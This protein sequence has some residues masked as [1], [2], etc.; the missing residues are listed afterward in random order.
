MKPEASQNSCLICPFS[1]ETVDRIRAGALELREER[2][3]GFRS[4]AKAGESGRATSPGL[5]SRRPSREPGEAAGDPGIS[6]GESLP[7][8]REL[9][10]AAAVNDPL[11]ST[12][13]VRR[14]LYERL[15]RRQMQRCVAS[16]YGWGRWSQDPWGSYG[17]FCKWIIR[18]PDN[19]MA[20][21]AVNETSAGR[22]YLVRGILEGLGRLDYP[23]M[24]AETL[25][26]C[27]VCGGAVSLHIKK[28]TGW[29]DFCSHYPAEPLPKRLV[30]ER[31]G[32][33]YPFDLLFPEMASPRPVSADDSARGAGRVNDDLFPELEETVASFIIGPDSYGP[34]TGY[35][36][37]VHNAYL[38]PF[39]LVEAK[40]RAEAHSGLEGFLVYDATTHSSIA[41]LSRRLSAEE[42]RL[43]D[44]S[45][46]RRMIE[47]LMRQSPEETASK[48]GPVLRVQVEG[49]GGVTLEQSCRE[50]Q[51][52]LLKSFDVRSKEDLP[53]RLQ[54]KPLPRLLARTQEFLLE[55]A[56]KECRWQKAPESH[57]AERDGREGLLDL[58]KGKGAPDHQDTEGSPARSGLDL[59]RLTGTQLRVWLSAVEACNQGYELHS[60]KGKSF[61]QLWRGNDYNKNMRILRKAASRLK[62]D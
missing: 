41:E 10:H 35:R 18:V 33:V 38:W 36:F 14:C 26:T 46:S 6:D 61:S 40:R 7:L 28:H 22:S 44:R 15:N 60:K 4:V 53:L 48:Y 32:R 50:A 51:M 3:G 5:E 20:V 27:I 23:G 1:D 16:Y 12:H 13:Y 62:E 2:S 58:L 11:Q 29:E 45:Q 17:M 31:L 19:E 39:V 49:V 43:P 37:L 56:R 57:L 54:G 55:S 9:R 59:G 30:N 52:A 8:P 34:L 21:W 42:R 25:R 24:P 47:E